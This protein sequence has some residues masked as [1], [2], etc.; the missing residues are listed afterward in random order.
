M[1]PART[2][3]LSLL[4]ALSLVTARVPS[5]DAVEPERGAD[6]P[7]ASEAVPDEP[8]PSSAAPAGPGRTRRA[9]TILQIGDSH[10]AADFFT[11]QVRRALQAEFGDGGAGYLAPGRPRAGVRSSALKIEASPGWAYASLQAA[12]DDRSQFSLSGFEAATST[13]GETLTYS[14]EAPV[15]WDQIEVEAIA[16]PNGGAVSI[17][18]DGRV[19]SEFQLTAPEAN[20]IVIRLT[21][22]H[23][24]V[25]RVQQVRITTLT[26]APVRIS[27][28]AVRNLSS[29]VSVSAVGFP[30]ATA[31]II[32]RF[33]GDNLRQELKRMSP[34]IV[35][36]AFGTNE[37]FNDNLD[38]AAYRTSYRRALGRIRRALPSARIVLVAP[39]NANRLDPGCKAESAKALC[40]A[41]ALATGSEE[42]R[43]PKTCAWRVPP[44][45]AR[46]RDV[47]RRIAEEDK[48]TYWNWADV[49]PAECGAHEWGKQ[50]PPLMADDHVHMTIAG[51]RQSA[52][53]LVP[54]LRAVVAETNGRRDALP[55]N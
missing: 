13:A 11:G 54:V 25:D 7:A 31:D 55:D 30:G 12:K 27:G 10:T 34:D 33:D 45:L 46:V 50:T 32:N 5:A 40:V 28:V 47:Q 43:G 52:A 15:A 26:A 23:V 48:L 21:P 4:L 35:V 22:E 38:P 51:Y 39:P 8:A 2:L 42:R 29:G 17:S 36:L 37:G 9:I 24:K 16:Q 49:M 14:A 18:L 44:G 3:R 1:A 53:R 19:E 20:R 41:D 6:V